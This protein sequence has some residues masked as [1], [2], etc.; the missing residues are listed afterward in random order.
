MTQWVYNLV[1]LFVAIVVIIFQLG[2][3]LHDTKIIEGG[4]VSN[5]ALIL[6]GLLVGFAFTYKINYVK[7]SP[8]GVK[9]KRLQ[10]IVLFTSNDCYHIHHFIWMTLIIFIVLVERQV[11]DKRYVNSFIALLIGSSLVDLMYIDWTLIKE[12]CHENKIMKL[13]KRKKVEQNSQ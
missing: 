5:N 9:K 7:G 11:A 8:H 4:N 1:F 2:F 6:F 12:D 3:N 13:F 10:E